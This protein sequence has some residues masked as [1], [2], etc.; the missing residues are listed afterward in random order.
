METEW[1]RR[2]GGLTV[3]WPI[4]QE[5]CANAG[6]N[7]F[8]RPQKRKLNTWK[9]SVRKVEMKWEDVVKR[10]E[11]E[12]RGRWLPQPDKCSKNVHENVAAAEGQKRHREGGKGGADRGVGD[13]W[14]QKKWKLRVEPQDEPHFARHWRCPYAPLC[15][16]AS[17]PARVCVCVCN[18]SKWIF[19]KSPT[20]CQ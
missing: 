12:E 17:Q 8:Q 16:P 14:E 18:M 3:F 13:W 1:S 7:T 5:T 11:R 2:L 19:N 10:R 15:L 4:H 20:C 9:E 6:Q